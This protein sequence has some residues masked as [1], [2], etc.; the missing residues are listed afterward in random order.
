MRDDVIICTIRNRNYHLSVGSNQ[1]FKK[2]DFGGGVG[3]IYHKC[4]LI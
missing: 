4:K 3:G 2:L 1:I